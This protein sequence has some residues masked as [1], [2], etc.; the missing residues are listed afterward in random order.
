MKLL[1]HLKYL[2]FFLLILLL[3][4]AQISQA[5]TELF[6]PQ[7]Q[8][9][10]SIEQNQSFKNLE[11]E[12][13]PNIGFL[14][15]KSKFEASESVSA[16]NQHEFSEYFVG[17]VA[18]VGSAIFK[19][20]DNIVGITVKQI[21]KGTNGKYAIIG[22]S[23][24]NAEV[25]GVKNVYSELKN[26]RNLNV[27]IFDASSLTGSWKTAFD[28]A[29]VEIKILTNNYDKRI[30]NSELIKTKMY[31]LNKDWVNKLISEG[32]TVLDMGD[33]NNKGFSVFYAME[34]SLIF[35]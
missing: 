16:Q 1:E 5:K 21:K 30:P 4:G 3:F 31:N 13:Q 6:L 32:Y 10:F 33:F 27:E 34:K 35:K 11:K 29:N 8:V 2:F 14:K 9:P 26:T 12:V 24:G 15:E 23:M 28:D 20:G 25:T 22:R 7:N 17:K 18:K 19:A